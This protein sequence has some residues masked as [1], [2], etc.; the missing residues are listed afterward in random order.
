MP[1]PVSPLWVH[2]QL[3]VKTDERLIA[4]LSL[5]DD[6]GNVIARIQGF[7]STRL[8]STREQQEFPKLLYRNYWVAAPEAPSMEA[9]SQPMRLG[10]EVRYLIGNR[11]GVA[12]GL[13]EKWRQ[14]GCQVILWNGRYQTEETATMEACLLEDQASWQSDS[15]YCKIPLGRSS[16]SSISMA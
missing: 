1:A 2:A 9:S 12:A 3:L 7:E 4:N 10:G 6:S 15:S 16:V 8:A 11:H 13:A 14:Q 5:C